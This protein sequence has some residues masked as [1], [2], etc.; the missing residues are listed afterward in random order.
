V[1][2]FVFEPKRYPLKPGCYLTK[3][4]KGQVIYIG[5]AKSLRR[6]LANYFQPHWKDRK[7]FWLVAHIAAIEVILVTNETESLVLENN[8]IKRFKPTYNRMLMGDESGY[9][10][11]VLTSERFPR[12][13]P[14]RKRRYN[15]ALEG[16]NE[17]EAPERR[18]GP[19]LGGH[20]RDALLEFVS[21]NFQIRNYK[22]LPKKVCLRYH[23]HKCSGICTGLIAAEENAQSV[24]QAVAFLNGQYSVLIKQMK[25]RMWEYSEKL[26][27]ERAQRIRDQVATLESV[28][29]NQ[30]VE[31]DIPFDQDVIYFG[32]GKV[33]VAEIKH[34]I[35]KGMDLYDLTSHENG[36]DESCKHFLVER[37]PQTVPAELIT[38][39]LANPLEVETVLATACHHNVKIIL[40]NPGVEQDLLNL[41]QLNLDYRLSLE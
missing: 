17:E 16:L 35:M 13:L 24:E 26:E 19:Y 23:L 10:Y 18:F 34:G 12:F 7:T 37:Y 28:L 22:V 4:A 11:I 38:N 31:R 3:D 33:L 9:P 5:K 15:K 41:C 14:Y 30:I 2:K 29:T 25:T 6:R 40:P 27:F 32:E 8:L 36:A 21:E 1:T 20:Y 39:H